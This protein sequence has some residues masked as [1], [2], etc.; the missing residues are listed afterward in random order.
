[1][2]ELVLKVIFLFVITITL[3]ACVTTTSNGEIV[4]RQVDALNRLEIANDY[5]FSL[6]PSAPWGLD[7]VP[8]GQIKRGERSEFVESFKSFVEHAKSTAPDIPIVIGGESSKMNSLVATAALSDARKGSLSGSTFIFFGTEKDYIPVAEA[9]KHAGAK[10]IRV[11]I[12]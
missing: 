9:I 4:D 3:T 11:D 6:T 10:S 12:P 8:A 1:M 5:L 7:V 2:K